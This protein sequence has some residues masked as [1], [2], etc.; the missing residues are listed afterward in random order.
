MA[1]KN[2]KK[3]KLKNTRLKRTGSFGSKMASTMFLK[4]LYD[5]KFLCTGLDSV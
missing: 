2:Y 3:T 5:E 1:D 4:F